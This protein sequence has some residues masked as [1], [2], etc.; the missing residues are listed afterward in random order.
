MLVC[1]PLACAV[2]VPPG[3]GPPDST[4]PSIVQTVPSDGQTNFSGSTVEFEF[5]EA[6]NVRTFGRALSITPDLVGTPRISGS[7]KKIKVRLPG[8]LRESTTYILTLDVSL[9]DLHNVSLDSPISIAFSTGDEIDAGR[10]SGRLVHA[11]SGQAAGGV[12]VFAF[13]DNDSLTLRSPPLYRT[14][15]GS[16]GSFRFN[17][18]STGEYF[19]VA[20]DDANRNRLMDEGEKRA[21]PP[22]DRISADS[23][24]AS[25]SRPWIL[26]V[27]DRIPPTIERVRAVSS[28]DLELRFSEPLDTDVNHPSIFG[29][30]ES[31]RLTLQDSLGNS[32][33]DVGELYFTESRSR[34]LFARVDSLSPGSYSLLGSAP[35]SDSLGNKMQEGVWPFT[36]SSLVS[37]SAPPAFLNW[38]PD[39]LVVIPNQARRVWNPERF[40][41]R[42]SSPAARLQISISDTTGAA[43]DL[44]INR[45]DPTYFEIGQGQRST[46]D[47]P[48]LVEVEGLQP[49]TTISGLFQF[50]SSR[51]S[52]A[53]VLET[54]NAS[55]LIVVE[56]FRRDRDTLPVMTI[57]S[58]DPS[59]T[60]DGLPGGF[61][62]RLRV[63]V[64]LDDSGRWNAGSLRPFQP[65][66][67]VGWVVADEPVRARWDTVLPDT[68]DLGT[69]PADSAAEKK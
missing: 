1:L 44:T 2:P 62:A 52:G 46:Q 38:T 11:S 67:P 65:S 35:V 7:G 37:E 17:Y 59:I 39:S 26:A 8:E 19:V 5:D 15:T 48:F 58:Q 25:P 51:L 32:V 68:L 10:M 41:I 57:S 56:V 33:G 30:A 40:G 63:Y 22:L 20:V 21:V 29:F 50:A 42:L 14:Q 61:R 36:V 64:D 13:A 24:G 49:D 60:L 4:P 53:L 6:I 66:E 28:R 18:V 34:I 55:G 16:N 12:D 3:G 31:H 9:R 69:L 54:K 45:L 27:H 47:A 23:L 43:V